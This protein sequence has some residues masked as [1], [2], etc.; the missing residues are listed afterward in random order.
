MVRAQRKV[1]RE[2]WR[3]LPMPTREQIREASD[4][5]W[6]QPDDAVDGFFVELDDNAEEFCA[7]HAEER[8]RH[9]ARFT[10]SGRR[11]H[12]AVE[13]YVGMLG[14]GQSDGS[15]WC[16]NDACGKRLRACLTDYGV[17]SALGL[18]EEDPLNCG[19]D[20]RDL[21]EADGA[22]TDDDERRRL[23]FHR[24]NELRTKEHP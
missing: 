18:T 2:A 17:D 9:V 24:Y 21:I 6:S 20:V 1:D 4:W 3:R 16:A 11:R 13:T 7:E 8:R 14:D 12:R 15:R 5:V 23:W 22:M 10:E 19:I